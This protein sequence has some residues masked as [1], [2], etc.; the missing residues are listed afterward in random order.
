MAVAPS[1]ANFPIAEGPY[2]KNGKSYVRILKG[3]GIVKEVRWYDEK[4]YKKSFSSTGKTATPTVQKPEYGSQR[5]ALGFEPTGSITIV[6]G[7]TYE[8]KEALKSYG[9]R[10]CRWWGWYFVSGSKLPSSMPEGLRLVELPWTTVSS[11]AEYLP[12]DEKVAE[13]LDGLLY[14]KDESKYIGV[15]GER[16]PFQVEIEKIVSLDSYY[17]PSKMYQFRDANRNVLIWTTTTAHDW[18]VGDTLSIKATIKDHKK[19]KNMEQTI[20]TRVFE[21]KN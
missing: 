13:A 19:Y 11:D 10:Y 6:A 8:H 9:A 3:D 21:L 5:I 14:E 7:S 2:E 12:T 1:F 18:S 16:L 17:G 15:V 4:E 20:I